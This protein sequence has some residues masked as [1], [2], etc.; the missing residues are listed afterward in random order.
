MEGRLLGSRRVPGHQYGVESCEHLPRCTGL[1]ECG[2][3]ME[4]PVRVPVVVLWEATG[5]STPVTPR[6]VYK[7][8]NKLTPTDC[9]PL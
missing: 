8:G 3:K 6:A 5:T 2:R 9:V 1:V 7:Y 4:L